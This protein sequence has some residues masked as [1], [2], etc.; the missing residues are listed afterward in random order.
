MKNL[1]NEYLKLLAERESGVVLGKKWFNLWLLTT[2]LAATFLSI[3]FSNGSMIYLSEKMNDPFTNWV[4]I[5]NGFGSDNFDD[6]REAIAQEDVQQH[7]G[8]SDVQSDNY[9]SL[10]MLGKDG[11]I[12][13]LQCRFFERLNSGLV[14]AILS[15]ENVVAECAISDSLLQDETYGFV[16]TR[17]VLYKLGYTEDS[18]PAY[19]NYLSFSRGA[20]SCG[21]RMIEGDFAAAPV[22]VLGVVRRLPMNM[23]IIAAKFFYEQYN[24]DNTYPLNLNNIEYQRKLL[25]YIDPSVVDF[26]AKVTGLVP[27]TLKFTLEILEDPQPQLQS[28]KPGKMMSIYI[29]TNESPLEVYQELNAQILK[30]FPTDKVSR[31]YDYN[32]SDFTLTLSS[33]VSVNFNNLDSIRAF[34]KFAKEQYNVQIEMS[35]VNSKENF[36]AV[37]VMANIL[38]LAMIVFSII[39][40]IMFF[41]NMLQSYFQKVKHNLGTFKA[42]GMGS[43][44]LIRVYVLIL[45]AIVV[46]AVILALGVAWLIQLLLPIFGVLKDGEF[47]YLSLW[48]IKT[49]LSIIIVIVATVATVRVVMSKLLKQ[50]P[51][52][53]IYDRD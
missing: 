2:V 25:Y 42:F 12:H 29:G 24:N 41:V 26:E 22:P 15:P 37:S 53:L 9:F 6:F 20:D 49:L 34:E 13:Y 14:H 48:S 38:S 32:S 18:I 44:E 4:N 39:C 33:F 52:D 21:V 19:I 40:I 30:T 8:F 35:Q 45:L 1:L 7:Y 11:G 17:D 28:W 47:N 27:D 36:N 5:S 46:S 51:G 3:S 31:L 16:L 23:D 10:S 43:D 50:T